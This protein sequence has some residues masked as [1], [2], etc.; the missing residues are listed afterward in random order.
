MAGR[1]N[2]PKEPRFIVKRGNY[3]APQQSFNESNLRSDW[4]KEDE[5][6]ELLSRQGRLTASG[7]EAPSTQTLRKACFTGGNSGEENFPSAWLG[8]MVGYAVESPH[9][10][11]RFTSGQEASQSAPSLYD[12]KRNSCIFI[13]ELPS[14]RV[15]CSRLP[16]PKPL[17]PTLKVTWDSNIKAKAAE[18]VGPF[19]YSCLSPRKRVH[20][21]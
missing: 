19:L 12:W 16:S 7:I 8:L 5:R 4:F 18:V 20:I 11:P 14:T 13:Y 15:R 9:P 10:P 6:C 21:V 17:F 2:R 1:G 3:R